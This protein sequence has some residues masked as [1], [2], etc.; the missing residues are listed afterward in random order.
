MNAVIKSHAQPREIL[1]LLQNII[2]FQQKLSRK[3]RYQ[4]ELDLQIKPAAAQK[5]WQAGQPL[6]GDE[7]LPVPPRL[8][9]ESLLDFCQ[10]LPPEGNLTHA[11]NRLMASNWVA[12][13]NLRRLLDE[14]F[15]GNEACLERLS[16]ATGT[17]QD[18]LTF[19]LRVILTPFFERQARPYR[20]WLST[21]SWRRGTCP[22]CGSEPW[23]AR[24]PLNSDQRLLV[25]PLCHTEWPFTRL[26]C[27]FCHSDAPSQLRYLTVNDDET[28]WAACC[29]HC[30]RYLKTVNEHTLGRTTN[31]L[32]EDVTTA[33]LDTLAHNKGYH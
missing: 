32:I 20:E 10:F 11:L 19:L 28:H 15:E 22:I 31:L 18:T 13:T 23:M 4:G 6:L 16:A 25:C 1:D 14:M 7:P 30:R 21:V 33:E 5:R 12:P 2:D 26:R 3:L 8:F 27:P 29:D 9:R 17:T 24:L